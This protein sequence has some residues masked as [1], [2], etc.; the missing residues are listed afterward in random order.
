MFANLNTGEKENMRQEQSNDSNRGFFQPRV[1]EDDTVRT[2]IK[3]MTIILSS[4]FPW[5][6]STNPC[7]KITL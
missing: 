6:L 5:Q 7:Q 3:N 4:S 1:V 2:T